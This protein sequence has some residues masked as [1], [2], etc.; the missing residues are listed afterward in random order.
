[1]RLLLLAALWAA[2]AAGAIKIDGDNFGLPDNALP[3][4]KVRRTPCGS[5]PQPLHVVRVRSAP[6]VSARWGP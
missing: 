3:M 4:L 5:W 1:M 2:A 6:R